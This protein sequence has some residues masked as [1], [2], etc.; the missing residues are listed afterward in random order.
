[1]KPGIKGYTCI[2]KCEDVVI[3]VVR[4]VWEKVDNEGIGEINNVVGVKGE[5]ANKVAFFERCR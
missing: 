5:D 4:K 1:M 3:K 2:V